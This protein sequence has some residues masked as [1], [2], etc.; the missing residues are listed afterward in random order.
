MNFGKFRSCLCDLNT[1]LKAVEEGGGGGAGLDFKGEWTT[2]GDAYDYAVGDA[3]LYDVPGDGFG[4]NLYQ[5]IT[6]H[7]SDILSPPDG[8]ANWV[9]IVGGGADGNDTPLGLTMAVTS[10]NYV[11]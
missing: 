10:G 3:V 1:R 11:N 6:A 7:T 4:A 2:L 8:D 5:A 9:L